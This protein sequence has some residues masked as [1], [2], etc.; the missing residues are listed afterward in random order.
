MSEEYVVEDGVPKTWTLTDLGIPGIKK[1]PEIVPFII[2]DPEPEGPYGAKGIA[3]ASLL[4]GAPAIINAIADATG[5]QMAVLGAALL[6]LFLLIW[7]GRRLARFAPVLEADL[8][9]VFF[10]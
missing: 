10:S 4:P 7:M 1:A 9:G 6:T 8:G 5:V 3:E 2:E